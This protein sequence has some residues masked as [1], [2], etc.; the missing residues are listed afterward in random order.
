[1]DQWQKYSAVCMNVV[2]KN[3]QLVSACPIISQIREK[4]YNRGK[5]TKNEIINILNGE[6]S[7]NFYI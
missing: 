1:M 7:E 4:L 5:L 6:N 3:Q 2:E